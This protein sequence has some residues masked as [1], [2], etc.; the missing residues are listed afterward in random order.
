MIHA[1]FLEGLLIGWLHTVWEKYRICSLV[2]LIP[3][4]RKWLYPQSR[5]PNTLVM[6]IAV[7]LQSRQDGCLVHAHDSVGRDMRQKAWLQ[8]REELMRY[9]M[10]VLI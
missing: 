5:T 2:L 4:V 1:A 6:L 7:S 3:A 10:I 8:F 9:V